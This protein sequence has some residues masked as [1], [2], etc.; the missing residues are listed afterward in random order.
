[1]DLST[2]NHQFNTSCNSNFIQKKQTSA[3]YN[4][5]LQYIKPDEVSVLADGKIVK[6]G[7]FELA[8]S[9]EKEGFGIVI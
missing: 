8:E 2:N 3:N 6:Q 7:G 5:F 1:M 9:I 4:K